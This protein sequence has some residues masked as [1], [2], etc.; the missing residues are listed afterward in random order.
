MSDLRPAA[1]SGRANLYR[2][3]DI[4][5]K[6]ALRGVQRHR[7]QSPEGRRV[8]PDMK[9]RGENLLMGTI[10]IGMDH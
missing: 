9:R 7:A 6:S 2:G 3:R 5:Q 10:P 8:F 4:R 1:I